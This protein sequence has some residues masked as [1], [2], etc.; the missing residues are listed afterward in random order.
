MNNNNNT[1]LNCNRKTIMPSFT[2][3]LHSMSNTQCVQGTYT[4]VY[5]NGERFFPNGTTYVLFGT[6]QLPVLF[7]NSFCISFVVP[8]NT[9]PGIY[10]VTVVNVYNPNF[11]NQS[12]A[13]TTTNSN[14]LLYHIT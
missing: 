8:L 6:I 12:Y 13:G 11:T 10:T 5:L 14:T 7:F 4:N 9:S 3:I 2:P 1:T